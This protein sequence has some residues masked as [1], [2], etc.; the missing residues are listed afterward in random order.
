VADVTNPSAPA[1]KGSVALSGFGSHVAVEGSLATALSYDSGHDYLDLINVSS[2]FFPTR[3]DSLLM[4]T[5]HLA[6]GVDLL[7]EV[8]YVT[9]GADGLKA[10]RVGRD[11]PAQE[12]AGVAGRGNGLAEEIVVDPSQRGRRGGADVID[13]EVLDLTDP[14]TPK[15]VSALPSTLS[16]ITTGTAVALNSPGT[17]GVA[18]MGTAGIEV[19]D[20]TNPAVPRIRGVFDTVG[21]ASAV[22]LNNAATIAY[23]ADGGNGHL[24]IVNLSNPNF[25]TLAGSLTS[26]IGTQVDIAIV[27]GGSTTTA[28]LGSQSGLMQGVDVTNPSTPALRGSVTLS[29]FASR[30]AAAGALAAVLSYNV[31]GNYLD[32]INVSNSFAPVRVASVYLGP[33]GTALGVALVNGL[34]YVAVN[35][36]GLQIYDL[37]N[38]AAPVLRNSVATI[39]DAVGIA[40]TGC[41]AYVA[42]FPATV[43]AI[44][45]A[46]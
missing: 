35:A 27:E 43:D 37:A 25:P 4:Q 10:D 22:A 32:I 34:A 29:G 33:S 31:S 14:T 1:L 18:V 38:P 40:V 20:L 45:L 28:Y 19:L 7:G 3:T 12:E 21:S 46:P 39:G 42:D 9:N 17:L 24:Q 15:V 13:L 16:A 36:A 44:S 5:A 8:A 23:V 11:I 26:I 41:F 2:P 6:T 30:V